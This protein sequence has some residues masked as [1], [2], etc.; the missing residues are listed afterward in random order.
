MKAVWALS[1]LLASAA[2]AEPMMAE[3]TLPPAA[4]ADTPLADPSQ[5]AAAQAL[6]HE[7][8]CLVCQNQTI[9]DS[10]ADMAGDMRAVV[11]TRIAAGHSPKAVRDW[12]ID[13]Y[14]NWV[15]FSPPVRGSTGLLWL[16]PLLFLGVGALAARRLFRKPKP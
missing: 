7:L 14:G 15:S 9:A 12:L 3:P 6:M 1:L 2:L 4:L 8:R 11:R 5:E 16:A 10:H 13:R